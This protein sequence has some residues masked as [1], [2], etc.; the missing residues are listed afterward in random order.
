MFKLKVLI[1]SIPPLWCSLYNFHRA[2][3]GSLWNSFTPTNLKRC[4]NWKFQS[5]ENVV[6][7]PSPTRRKQTPGFGR[8]NHFLQKQTL[9]FKGKASQWPSQFLWLDVIDQSQNDNIACFNHPSFGSLII[10]SSSST[11]SLGQAR[12]CLRRG[13]EQAREQTR[14]AKLAKTSWK[15]QIFCKK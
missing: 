3:T 14:K 9:H 11:W 10:I 6:C 2:R 12:T 13:N 5:E 1:Q 15:D 8:R 7:F 4:P